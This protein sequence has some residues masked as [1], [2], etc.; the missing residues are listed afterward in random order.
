MTSCKCTSFHRTP[1]ATSNIL[2]FQHNFT[3]STAVYKTCTHIYHVHNHRQV[4]D[5]T[6]ISG[7]MSEYIVEIDRSSVFYWLAMRA[8]EMQ[9]KTFLDVLVDVHN[10]QN[11]LNVLNPC[12]WR[13]SIRRLQHRLQSKHKMGMRY[14]I[15][16]GMRRWCF[17]C[18]HR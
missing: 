14:P 11:K 15:Q 8:S 10:T 5:V 18:S 16:V 2:Y 7:L 13:H 1:T 17:C 12:G 3:S 4:Q 9:R 6:P